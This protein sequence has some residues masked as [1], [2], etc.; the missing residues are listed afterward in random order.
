MERKSNGLKETMYSW[1]IS[2]MRSAENIGV[3]VKVDGKYYTMRD[4]G[5]L[6]HVMENHYYMKSYIGDEHGR[7]QEINF[8]HITEF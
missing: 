4:A 5:R 1:V 6:H 7:I 8:D 3:P 2:E